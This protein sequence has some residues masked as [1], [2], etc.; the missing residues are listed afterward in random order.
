MSSWARPSAARFLYRCAPERAPPIAV[1]R[2]ELDAALPGGTSATKDR[3]P[4]F[5]T[6]SYRA[7]SEAIVPSS[8]LST[9]N[10]SGSVSMP[11]SPG[12]LAAMPS[13]TV[14][15]FGIRRSST[16][17][18]PIKRSP[19]NDRTAIL[20]ALMVPRGLSRH[21]QPAY[22]PMPPRIAGDSRRKTLK[23]DALTDDEL[24]L[25]PSATRPRA[26][27]PASGSLSRDR[28]GLLVLLGF[29]FEGICPEPVSRRPASL[30][31]AGGGSIPPCGSHVWT[32]STLGCDRYPRLRPTTPRAAPSSRAIGPSPT[33]LP[34]WGLPSALLPA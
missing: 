17:A 30:S 11:T 10:T 2:R 31:A 33:W 24:S 27:S 16:A 25:T 26:P 4:W 23:Y 7:A 12:Y 29:L 14:A 32:L 19:I 18:A 21:S 8:N 1:I 6:S 15:G 22:L 34:R 9:K 3:S 5:R 20:D 28:A 13:V